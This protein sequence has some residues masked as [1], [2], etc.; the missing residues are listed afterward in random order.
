MYVSDYGFA[1]SNSAWTS[2]ISSYNSSSITSNNW[3][4]M[5]L[6]EWTISRSSS[7]TDFVYIV[8][9]SGHLNYVSVRSGYNT[10]AIRPVFYLTSD[11]TYVSGDGSINSPIRIN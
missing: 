10:S 5:G 9:D 7:G 2:N 3:M 1:A 6:T 11:V 8:G 4:Y